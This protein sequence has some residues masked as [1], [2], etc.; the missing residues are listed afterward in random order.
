MRTIKEIKA[1]MTADFLADAT[2][3]EMYGLEVGDRFEDKFSTVSL[4]NILF[5]IVAA[6]VYVVESLFDR[7]AKEMDEVA[8]KS[9]VASVPWYYERVMAY[10]HGDALVLN[11][12]T[13]AYGYADIAPDRQV[14]KYAAVRDMGTWLKVLASGEQDKR[15]A[16]LDAE[17]LQGLTA[18]IERVKVAGVIVSVNSYD[19]DKI[20]VHARVSIDPLVLRQEDGSRITDDTYPVREAI[21]GYLSSVVYGGALNKTK[22]VDAMQEAPGVVD[23]TLESVQ[24]STDGGETYHEV[25]GNNYQALGGCFVAVALE[26]TLSYVVEG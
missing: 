15:P 12:E 9:L 16:A 18:Y 23:V 2:I 22:L 19:P 10:Q 4:E 13:M 1:S 17:Q 20:I 14:V 21:E 24:W 8:E 5:S 25:V 3:R 6:C 26:N 11:P 7:H